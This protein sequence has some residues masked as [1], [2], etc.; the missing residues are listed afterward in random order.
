MSVPFLRV[1]SEGDGDEVV[2]QVCDEGATRCGSGDEVE[3]AADADAA[4][5]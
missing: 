5:K 3:L 2:A 4:F 1:L